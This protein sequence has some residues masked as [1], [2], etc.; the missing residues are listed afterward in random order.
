[1][2][3]IEERRLEYLLKHHEI[4][5]SLI[6][7]TFLHMSYF[8]TSKDEI[9]EKM[10]PWRNDLDDLHVAYQLP[11]YEAGIAHPRSEFINED[12]TIDFKRLHDHI[13]AKYPKI[14]T[15]LHKSELD[16]EARNQNT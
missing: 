9:I 16:D 14:L 7:L 3:E 1:M 8:D 5:E 6:G 11:L 4:C 12:G 10:K 13:Q 2:I 15:A